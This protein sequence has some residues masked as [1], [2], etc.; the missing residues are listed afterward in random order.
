MSEPGFCRMIWRR[1][2][3]WP[4]AGWR[5]WNTPLVTSVSPDGWEYEADTDGG[6]RPPRWGG[7]VAPKFILNRQGPLPGES[8]REALGRLITTD[9]QFA[10][11]VV[12]RVWKELMVVGLV[13]PAADWDLNRLDPNTT[14]P[15]GPQT[16]HPEL[17][18]LFGRG[19]NY[20]EPRSGEGSI[21]QSLAVMN[22]ILV[23]RRSYRD[24]WGTT[25]NRIQRLIEEETGP[26]AA[27]E[28]LFLA[29]L[30]RLPTAR[31]QAVAEQ[32]LEADPAGGLD[33]L[34]W[35]LVNTQEFLFRP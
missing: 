8:R 16:L 1:S 6:D 11:N 26:T 21:S 9:P 18:N 20:D 31:E 35:A 12:N 14:S 2:I 4:G 3:R 5:R 28:E 15:L 32:A 27:V 29:T 22:S 19:N 34:F 33:D 17:L 7:P 30:S 23:N 13:E 24:D 25:P 10:R